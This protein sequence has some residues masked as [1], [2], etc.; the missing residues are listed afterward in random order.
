M[1]QHPSA[2]IEKPPRSWR[3]V[4]R[5]ICCRTSQREHLLLKR[6]RSSQRR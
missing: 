1:L 3:I 2:C 4:V 6:S 5:Q